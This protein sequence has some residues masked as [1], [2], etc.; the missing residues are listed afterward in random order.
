MHIVK[1]LAVAVATVAITLS[2]AGQADAKVK[3]RYH[4]HGRYLTSAPFQVED[5]P[6]PPVI[7]P[8]PYNPQLPDD[9]GCPLP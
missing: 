5:P 3:H 4:N 6:L 9:G 1:A 2:F 7:A 8:P